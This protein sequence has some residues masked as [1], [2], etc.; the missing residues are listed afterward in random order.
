MEIMDTQCALE[1]VERLQAKL[2]ERGEA[3]TQE[4]LSVL[5]TVLQSPLFHHIL[6][7]QQA[8]QKPPVK[9]KGISKSVSMNC[10]PCQ[11]MGLGLKTLSHSDSYTWAM[12]NRRPSTARS[13]RRDSSMSSLGSQDLSFSDIYPENCINA[14]SQYCTPPRI[15]RTMSMGRNL[16]AIAHERRHVEM[17]ELINDGKGLGFGIIG[18][19]STGVMVKTILPGGAAG[20]DNRLRSGDQILRIGETDLVGMNSEQVAQVLRNAGSKVKLLIARDV[21]K[22][23][24][25]SS[26]VLSQDSLDGKLNDLNNDCEFSVQFT[27][28]SRGLGF[29]ISSYIGD[30]NSVY[31][32]G[33]IVKSIVKGST[34]DQ[35][36]RIHIGDIIL[37]VDGVSLHGCS[38]QRAMEVLRRTGPLVRLRLL[39]K[40]V[41]L[42]HILPPVPPLQPLR[43][44]HSFHEGNPY[45]VG[46]NKIQET[47]ICSLREIS[48]QAAYANRKPRYD[49]R[50]GAKLTSAEEEDLRKR[51][52][53]AVGPRYEVICCQLERFSETSGLGISLEARAG[54]HYLCSVL[55]EGPVGQSGKIFTGDQILEVNGIP[56][57]GQTHKEVVSILKELPVC[58]CLVCSRIVPPAVHDSDEDGDDVHLT[59]K[60]LLAE[61]NDKLDQGCIIP[62]PTAEDI[63]KRGVPPMSPPLAMWEKEAQVVELE[64]G[65]SGLGFSILDYQDPEDATKTVLVIRSLVPGGVADRDGRLLPG[66]RLMFVN[67][68]DL[69]GSSLD[70]AVHVLKSSGYGPVHIG[71]AKPLPLELCGG[72]TPIS[73]RST[74]ASCDDTESHTQ[75]SLLAEAAEANTNTHT[76]H[77]EDNSTILPCY[78]ATENQLRQRFNIMED[79]HRQTAPPLPP[80]T[81]FERT[82]TVVRGNCSLGMSVSAIKDGSGMLVRSV[83]QGGCVSQDGRLGVGDAILA[84]NEEPTSNLTNT[85]AR[86]MLRRQS[87]IG[88]EIRITYVP[89]NQVDEFRS[90]LGLTPMTSITADS[91]SSSPTPPAPSPEPSSSLTSS[92]SPNRAPAPAAAPN[93][94]PSSSTL[95]PPASVH[96]N[97]PTAPGAAAVKPSATYKSPFKGPA[98]V[99][100]I[101]PA[102]DSSWQMPKHPHKNK[103]EENKYAESMEKRK[104]GSADGKVPKVEVEIKVDGKDQRDEDFHSHTNASSDQPRS[105][106]LTRAP[107]QSLGISI[108]GGR[109]MGRRLS[110]G[111][112][113]RGVFIKHISPDS[114]A[115]HNGTLRTGDRILEVC[116][117][118][119]RDASHEQAVETIRKAGDTVIFLVQSGQHRSQSPLL[120]NNERLTPSPQ[121]NSHS[122]KVPSPTSDRAERRSPISV[123][124]QMQMAAEDEDN[125]C[126]KKMLQRYGSLS[127]KLHM[128][129][130]EKDPEAQ[131]LGI[132][133]RGNKDGSRAR[134]SVYVEHIDPRGPAGLDGRIRVGDELLEINGQ[135]LYGRSHQ[136]ASTII[137]NAPSKVKIILIRNKAATGPT[138]KGSGTEH[139]DTVD[140]QTDSAE[141][142]GLSRDIQH[143]ILPQDHVGLGLCLT[144]KESKDGVVVQSLIQHGT[145]SKDGRIKVGDRIIGVGDEPVG[146][147]SIDKVSSLILKQGVTVK[148]SI[149]RSKS[150]TSSLSLPSS[151][152]CPSSFNP[153]SSHSFPVSA[154]TSSICTIPSST[155]ERTDWLGPTSAGPE[156][157]SCPIVPGKETA[158]EINKGNVGLG[159]SIVGGCDTL[160]GAVIIHEV[161]DGGAAQRDGRLQAGDQILE[162]NGIDLRQATHDEAIGVLRLT[163]QRVCLCVFRH[164]EAYREEDLWDVFS[165]ELRPRPGEGL[166]FSTVGK[167]NDTGIFVSDIIRGGVA[168]SDGRLLLGDQILSISGEDVRASSHEDAEKLLQKCSGV[169]HLE[170]ARFK[171]GLQYSQRSQEFFKFCFIQSED[172]DCSTLTPSSG[173]DTSF[174]HQT[175]IDSKTGSYTFQDHPDIKKVVIQKGPCDS[176]GISVAGGVG[177]PHGNVPLFIATMDTN[178]LAAKTQQLQTGNRI[179]SIND[180]STRGMTHVH[181]GALLKNTTGTIRLEVAAGAGGCSTQDHTNTNTR[182]SGQPSSLPC[183]H[184]NLCNVQ[185]ERKTNARMYKTITLERGS[186]GLG[187]SI[188]GGFGSPHGDLPIYVKSVFNKG[189]AVEDGRLKRGD[190]IIAVNGHCLEG[191]THAE[192]V[193][194]L[195]KTKGSV[196]LTVLS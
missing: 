145:A 171:A 176:L 55:P 172:S 22:D 129:E 174:G 114:P 80:R 13:F 195:K 101:T 18:G 150:P 92:L 45:R 25:L 104:D 111:E 84:I 11:G 130:L 149:S 24:H 83:V 108:M 132:R 135:I 4:K 154:S 65:E 189:A 94:T 21:I 181:A 193:D 186:S 1:A 117:F 14:E 151:I 32:A 15:S 170:V 113:M 8:Q 2:K 139:E 59:L 67:E 30:L 190:Q 6:S 20:R 7:L 5:K 38:E 115:A 86:A 182:W 68:T 184:N 60:E 17:I 119:L 76:V 26:P 162:V 138:G 127:G 194:I 126:R 69:E 110:S 185:R 131:G 52:Q 165:L 137:N 160:L 54:H 96:M 159:L 158:I 177:S 156:L 183:F 125:T 49:S 34:V 153:S 93:Q 48:R 81:G 123:T 179:L 75:V 161:N 31:S 57:I 95:K 105:V 155:T 191:V 82:I 37:S 192:A 90:R 9:G 168:D 97:A 175:E 116:G 140:S 29:T 107:G 77:S 19:R 169:V 133:L 99:P 3:P 50:K 42:S 28:N 106:R 102:P 79:D 128:I 71:V 178:G 196:V 78:T 46:L 51:W 187:F 152:S 88:P 100:T 163:T 72:L 141:G 40:A 85:K 39:R 144:E 56:L 142:G 166:G 33:V 180:V 136:N 62:C 36:G 122:N 98:I 47:G 89:A 148:L 16:S 147:Q 43:H 66:D 61:F 173:C 41:R 134:M 109:G 164:Q 188:V 87:V 73:E 74:R 103:E 112:M 157:H 44:S 146:R 12:E 143:I 58:V 121:S 64:K 120:A 167:S 53:H 10:G 91:A 23:N 124:T 70:Y 35:D 27:K 63:T 118:D